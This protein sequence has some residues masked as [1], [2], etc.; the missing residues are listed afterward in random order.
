MNENDTDL[1]LLSLQLANFEK[2]FNK[3]REEV[4]EIYCFVSGD[5]KKMRDYLEGK[6]NVAV[7]NALED[8]ALA[9]PED[10]PEF[11]I[12][13]QEKGL[14]EISMRRNFLGTTPQWVQE[15]L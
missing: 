8:M 15:T 5:V 11:I 3:S 14:K 9:K 1:Q 4:A 2:E 6:P 13:L 12:L 7:W 10:S